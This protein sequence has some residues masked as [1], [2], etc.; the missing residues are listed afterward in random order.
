M[1]LPDMRPEEMTFKMIKRITTAMA[2][3]DSLEAN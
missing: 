1:A 2:D 3:L